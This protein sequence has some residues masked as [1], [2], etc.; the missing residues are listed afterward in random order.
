MQEANLA[1]TKLPFSPT[2]SENIHF[3][4]PVLLP[5]EPTTNLH[6]KLMSVK[7]SHHLAC[8][9]YHMVPK[10]TQLV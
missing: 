8:H 3:F 10:M 5:Y 9:R 1:L 4:V 2:Y 7:V 6:V